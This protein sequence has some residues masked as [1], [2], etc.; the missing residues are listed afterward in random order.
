MALTHPACRLGRRAR[1]AVLGY[2]AL[3]GAGALV[4][5]A[6]GHPDQGTA[7]L[8]LATFPGSVVVGIGAFVLA[9]FL[10]VAPSTSDAQPGVFGQMLP[11]V[12]G[13]VVNAL[14]V[15]GVVAFARVVAGELREHRRY[16]G[17]TGG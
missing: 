7:Y 12:L 9:A 2:A 17:R 3:A 4:V 10:D 14:L 5:G 11:F 16:R 15:W 1:A 6:M 13:A 8:H